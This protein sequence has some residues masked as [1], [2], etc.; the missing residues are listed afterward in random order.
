MNIY[1]RI[2]GVW[3]LLAL[4]N[5]AGV[6]T[7][8]EGN[9]VLIGRMLIRDANALVCIISFTLYQREIRR[10]VRY[11]F[12]N[13][14]VFFF[15]GGLS[16]SLCEILIK[17]TSSNN[18]WV[19]FYYYQYHTQL[20]FLLLA[21]AVVYLVT[22]LVLKNWS[23]CARYVLAIAVASSVWGYLFFPYFLNPAYLHSTVD[24]LDYK[25]VRSAIENLRFKGIT[26]PSSEEIANNVL[27]D[28]PRYAKV[29]T[30]S[31]NQERLRRVD[32]IRPYF[33]GDDV[34]LL[35]F[36]PLW[37]S[38]FLIA[39][40]CTLTI[41]SFFVYQYLADPPGWA[42]LEKIVWCLLLYCGF[43][44]FHHYAFTRAQSWKTYEDLN[45]IGWYASMGVL[46][47]LF[48]FMALRLRFILSI[49]GRYHEHRL[50]T[51]ALRVTRWRDAF[52]TWV[53]R[54]FMDT[55]EIER[56][57]IINPGLNDK[58]SAEGKA[59]R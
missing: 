46:I 16:G 52:D 5:A 57:F 56:R 7:S 27:F 4:A 11:V 48:L 49:E 24:V 40:L 34:A 59:P 21:L 28:G 10:E 22:D 14:S 47:V 15:N 29:D 33:R 44:A 32:E 17:L 13:F 42:Y 54:Q 19:K 51:D 26:E 43:E 18:P 55:R 45:V 8:S 1:R 6:L 9:W 50:E 31:S 38:C 3:L 20:Y 35:V 23:V 36:R 30:Q 2:L 53:L 37:W 41:V 39:V 58:G 12:L 25:A